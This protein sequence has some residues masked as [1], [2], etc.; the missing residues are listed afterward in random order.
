MVVSMMGELHVPVGGSR[1]H[2]VWKYFLLQPAKKK[3]LS[4]CLIQE[5]EGKRE[6]QVHIKHNTYKDNP[7]GKRRNKIK[8]ESLPSL[9]FNT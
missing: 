5:R 1:E 9:F 7:Q 4:R 6:S 2:L 8:K 3:P